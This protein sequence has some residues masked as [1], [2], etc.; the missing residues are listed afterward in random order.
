MN[1]CKQKN[2]SKLNI[3]KKIGFLLSII[4]KCTEIGRLEPVHLNQLIYLLAWAPV[5]SGRLYKYPKSDGS[6]L[7]QTVICSLTLFISVRCCSQVFC[8]CARCG[9]SKTKN[10]NAT[11]PLFKLSV[12]S[13]HPFHCCDGE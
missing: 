13:V 4:L 11:Q 12:E 7:F 8:L 3:Y 9:S 5:G 10:R 6:T 1:E 2:F